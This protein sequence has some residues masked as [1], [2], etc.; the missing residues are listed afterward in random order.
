LFPVYLTYEQF[1]ANFKIR[2]YTVFA[3]SL[4]G[5]RFDISGDIVDDF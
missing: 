2:Q 3:K 5:I 1:V 4:N